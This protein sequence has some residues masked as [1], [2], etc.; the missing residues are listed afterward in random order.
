M[1][2][3]SIK[4]PPEPQQ[5][6]ACMHSNPGLGTDG[7]LLGRGKAASL[8]WQYNVSAPVITELCSDTADSIK[9]HE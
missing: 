7:K 8:G 6:A 2:T 4:H 1:A 5:A 3:F 9:V